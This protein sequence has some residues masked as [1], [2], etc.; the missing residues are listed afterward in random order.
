MQITT[1]DSVTCFYSFSEISHM[2]Y[3]MEKVQLAIFL[4]F[5][6]CKLKKISSDDWVTF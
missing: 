1:K 3:F 5:L 2:S 4:A 6:I